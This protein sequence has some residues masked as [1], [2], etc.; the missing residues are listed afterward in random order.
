MINW[1]ESAIKW[2]GRSQNLRESTEENH[3]QLRQGQPRFEPGFSR[4]RSRTLPLYQPRVILVEHFQHTHNIRKDSLCWHARILYSLPLA[5][6]QPFRKLH[7]TRS[8]FPPYF[9]TFL[10]HSNL[11]PVTHDVTNTHLI[12]V[13]HCH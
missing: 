3:G 10:Q 9:Q 1:N 2:S 11:I 7:P 8:H 12:P 13:I 6:V 4:N 5:T